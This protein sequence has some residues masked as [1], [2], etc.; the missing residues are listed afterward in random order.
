[1]KDALTS[2]VLLQAQAPGMDGSFF[3]MVGSILLIMYLLV[4]RPESQKRKQLEATIKAAEKGDE[5]VTTGG[6]QG[7]LTGTTEDIVTVEI[8][9][10]KSGERVRVKMQRSAI[11]SV[12]KAESR[13]E[14][15]GGDS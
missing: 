10:L 7:V 2:G 12:A 1:M 11:S 4:L 14:K 13:V 8:A 9:V 15:K 3:L 6:L 5:I